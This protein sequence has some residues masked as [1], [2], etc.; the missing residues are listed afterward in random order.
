MYAKLPSHNTVRMPVCFTFDSYYM[1]YN[2]NGLITEPTKNG[3]VCF[4][5]QSPA[6]LAAAASLPRGLQVQRGSSSSA[7]NGSAGVATVHKLAGAAATDCSQAMYETVP[8]GR[9][10]GVALLPATALQRP[11]S[12]GQQKT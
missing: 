10:P 6:K 9:L 11:M 2:N 5:L 1:A 12:G 8:G 3:L 4:S 7:T